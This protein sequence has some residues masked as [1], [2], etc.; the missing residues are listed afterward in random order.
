VIPFHVSIF[1]YTPGAMVYVQGAP[2]ARFTT[3]GAMTF[4]NVADFGPG[5]L[6]R[7]VG[8]YTSMWGENRTE[9]C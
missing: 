2:G 6:Q 4:D 8:I 5:V 1:S 9:A 3:G 7:A